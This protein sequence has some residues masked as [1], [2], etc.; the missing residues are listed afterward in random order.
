MADASSSEQSSDVDMLI[1][2]DYYWDVI[3]GDLK[4]SGNGPVAVSSKFGWLLSGPVKSKRSE[5]GFTVTNLVVEG[6]RKVELISEQHTDENDSELD[7]DFW[8]TKPLVSLKPVQQRFVNLK[9]DWKQGRC[10][11]PGRQTT[12]LRTLVMICAW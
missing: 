1:G 2:S 12:G 3:T 4:R 11:S 8:D 5:D 9:F 6:L 10:Q 7:E